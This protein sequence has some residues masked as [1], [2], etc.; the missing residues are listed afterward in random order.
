MQV[1]K[2]ERVLEGFGPVSKLVLPDNWL[3]HKVPKVNR[4]DI[5]TLRKFHSPDNIQI[6]FCA[7]YRGLPVSKSSGDLFCRHLTE[8]SQLED[9][10]AVLSLQDDLQEIL[11]PLAF[12]DDFT[13]EKAQIKDL[14]GKRVLEVEGVWPKLNLK[15]RNIFI[16]ASGDGTI[17]YELYYGAP[18]EEFNGYIETVDNALSSIIW[19]NDWLTRQN[20]PEN[21]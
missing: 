14:N 4:E 3:E 19:D 20:L 17:V 2:T 18:E 12:K 11:G 15:S 1:G 8:V 5:K 7:Y 9:E 10:K 21:R 6:Q 16:D 13:L